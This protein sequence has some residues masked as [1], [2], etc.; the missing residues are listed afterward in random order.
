MYDQWHGGLNNCMICELSQK[1]E[2]QSIIIP[3]DLVQCFYFILLNVKCDYL[4]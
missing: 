2:N 1:N 3:T 4:D